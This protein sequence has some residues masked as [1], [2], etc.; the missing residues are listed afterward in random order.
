MKQIPFGPSLFC[1]R[2]GPRFA[3]WAGTIVALCTFSP[4]CLAQIANLVDVPDPPPLPTP[5]LLERFVFVNPLPLAVGLILAWLVIGLLARAR[6]S[7]KHQR[8]AASIAMVVF[9]LGI[10]VYVAGRLITTP[11]ERM[12]QT[13]RALVAAVAKADVQTVRSSLTPDCMLSYF[14]APMGIPVQAILSRVQEQFTASGA[15]ALEDYNIRAISAIE[16]RDG[17]GRVQVKVWAKAKSGFP[18]N[19]WWSI[20]YTREGDEWKASAIQGISMSGR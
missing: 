18:V 10:A 9:C 6:Q 5:G 7:V 20:D 13:T 4:V 12:M 3:L 17:F 2:K 1:V 11:R 8:I 15:F 19:S 14:D 16:D